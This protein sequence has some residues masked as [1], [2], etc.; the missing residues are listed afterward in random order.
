MKLAEGRYYQR[1]RVE[2]ASQKQLI[3][4]AYD[5]LL[6]D[7]ETAREA[8]QAGEYAVSNDTLIHAQK[9]VMVLLEAVTPK[10]P[11]TEMLISFYLFLK[12]KLLQANVEK[13]PAILES[14]MLIVRKIRQA[15]EVGF[16]NQKAR[17]TKTTEQE[18]KNQK[19]LS[20]QL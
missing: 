18:A 4:M 14:L 11:G 20:V 16:T 10:E 19:R 6:E 17:G 1:A 13:D 2:T 15:W 12:R 3:L 7:I 8:I 9:I 5:G